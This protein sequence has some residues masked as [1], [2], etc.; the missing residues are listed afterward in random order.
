MKKELPITVVL[1]AFL[2][3]HPVSSFCGDYE[4]C[5]TEKIKDAHSDAAV[6]ELSMI[7]YKLTLPKACRG[8]KLEIHKKVLIEKKRLKN[9]EKIIVI[10]SKI[11]NLKIKEKS[12]IKTDDSVDSY[13]RS[14]SGKILSE[15]FFLKGLTDVTDKE[16]LASCREYCERSSIFSQKFGECSNDW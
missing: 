12:Y 11:N 10:E 7:C 2:L 9:K 13:L 15:E 4:S 14:P 6:R 1:V 3:I 8:N 5:I 16:A